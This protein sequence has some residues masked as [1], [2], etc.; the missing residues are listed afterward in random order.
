MQAGALRG[1][2]T[3]FAG[4]DLIGVGHALERAHD[5][6][7]QDPALAHGSR[8]ILELVIRET[9]PRIP[10]ARPQELDWNPT[11]ASGTLERSDLVADISN[12]S[13]ET[14]AKT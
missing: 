4:D 9:A 14:P 8:Q 12:Q 7:L 11:L 13:G 10:R 5:D 6:R 2:P 3:P 1:T